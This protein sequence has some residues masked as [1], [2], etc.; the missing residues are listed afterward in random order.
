MS[1][2]P[3]IIDALATALQNEEVRETFTPEQVTQVDQILNGPRPCPDDD[4]RYLLRRL[5][6][7]HCKGD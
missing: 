6:R 3:I 1:H 4:F 5:E 2:R 7:S